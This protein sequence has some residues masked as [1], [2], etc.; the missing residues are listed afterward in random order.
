MDGGEFGCVPVRKS[1]QDKLPS[2]EVQRCVCVFLW[3][4]VIL[5][6][7]YLS[8]LSI[9]LSIS[10][11]RGNFRTWDCICTVQ[12][13]QVPRLQFECSRFARCMLVFGGWLAGLESGGS[14]RNGLASLCG[15][16]MC[17]MLLTA[18]ALLYTACVGLFNLF[19]ACGV[20]WI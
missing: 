10:S 12:Y 2:W 9:Y 16:S 6:V 11:R 5:I 7:V 14:Y 20:W 3:R 19:C 13:L 1:L 8:T 4:W 15:A 17:V 18:F